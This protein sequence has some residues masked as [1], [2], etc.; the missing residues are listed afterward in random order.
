MAGGDDSLQSISVRL[1]GTN[2]TY[3]SFGMKNFLKGNKMWKYVFGSTFKPEKS[4]DTEKYDEL[5]DVWDTN[6]SKIITWIN[7]SV[8]HRIGM[9]LARYETAKE[10]WDYL[11]R[12]YVRSNFAVQYQLE[13]PDKADVS[14]KG[15]CQRPSPY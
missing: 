7:N 1:D 9:Q 12:L 15:V 14:G 4:E 5:L 13:V 6:N 8:E 3:W 11:Q 2:Y 10:V